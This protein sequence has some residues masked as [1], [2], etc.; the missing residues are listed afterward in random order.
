MN[1]W[2]EPGLVP[3]LCLGT[4]R[5]KLCFEERLVTATRSRASKRQ[6]P[7]RSLGTKGRPR[8]SSCSIGAIVLLLSSVIQAEL[9]AAG[10]EWS[11]RAHDLVLTVDTR[12]AGGA[13][14]GYYPIRIR[15][16]NMARPCV[17]DFV[18]TGTGGNGSPTVARQVQIDQNATQQLTLPIPL[19]AQNGYGQLNIYENGRK[20]DQLS[21][22]VALP[23]AQQ[24]WLDRPSLL[25]ISPTPATVDCSKFE[26]AVQ[27]LASQGAS[28][29]VGYWPGAPTP[30]SND[31]QAI[32]KEL[33]PESWIDYTALDIVAL[34]LATLEKIP[35]EA[36]GALLKWTAAGG[37]LI[38]FEVG[39]A[40][41]K[42]SDLARLLELSNRPPQS[43]TWRPADTALR[44]PI[45]I[46]VD[47]SGVTIV[48]GSGVMMASKPR[49]P[50]DAA[51]ENV[52]N[53]A[54]T[55]V[56]PLAPETFSK[57]DFLAGRVYAFPA[58]PFPGAPIDWGWWLN[59]ANL[60]TVKWTSRHGL[61][62][63][64]R[65]PEFFTFLIP[66]V[67]AVPVLEFVLLI[68]LFTVAIG[69]VNYFLLWKRRQLY[70]L[71]VTIPAIAFLTS[72]ALFG[73]AMLA[74]GFGVQSRL[75]SFTLL[76]Q[77]SKT[78]VSFNRISLYAGITPSAGLKFS[79]ETAVLPIWPDD[80]AF[81][82]GSVD[83]TN[84]QHLAN[85][86]LR[87]RTP[88][89]FETVSVRAERGRLDVRP[90]GEGAMDVSNGLEWEIDQLVVKDE[91]GRLFAGRKLPAGASTTLSTARADDLKALAA[92]LAA[93]PL[94]APAG[95][96]SNEP[97]PFDR[98]SRHAWMGY[99]AYGV[100]QHP[101]AFNSSLLET[102]L[103][104]LTKPAQ[105]PAA[106]G[107]VP[108]TYLATFSRNPGIEL[109]V[110]RTRP[111]AGL[112]VLMGYY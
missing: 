37:T 80:G 28:S 90:A 40:A 60:S 53:L 23:D 61:S 73:Y 47:P 76:D 2:T 97:N 25:V 7:K 10:S 9:F 36:R 82:T 15:M 27:S 48:P 46:A 92:A 87:S 52:V 111:S 84:T 88:A 6:I 66:G 89:Q 11:R 19:V 33:L 83:W 65:H 17:L 93:D 16:V 102:H 1:G 57:L 41:E 70:L 69:P 72:G 110:A 24:D 21:Q 105:E 35:A 22:H 86:W 78:A 26:D 108:R 8:S 12:W 98:R 13:N 96:A 34:P 79:P 18:F 67:G 3:K 5:P 63:R 77:Y 38:V 50:G 106:G 54:N 30:R 45:A 29:G 74:D 99:S 4:H 112:Y 107:L 42:S 91:K 31:F 101:A 20:L 85:G 104:L 44:R 56:W 59:S 71:V 43:Q 51:P 81:E 95:A 32:S 94:V 39:E 62:S 64:R 55:A 49:N 14:G 109:G 103:N 58:N 100:E 68:S 75:R